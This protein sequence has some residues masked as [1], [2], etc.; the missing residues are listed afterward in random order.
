MGGKVEELWRKRFVKK[1]SFEPEVHGS[2]E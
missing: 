2:E 1:M